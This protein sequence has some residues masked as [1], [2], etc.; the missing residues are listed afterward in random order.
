MQSSFPSI[1]SCWMLLVLEYHEGYPRWHI[2]N[3]TD[4]PWVVSLYRSESK[5]SSHVAFPRSHHPENS[6]TTSKLSCDSTKETQKLVGG[7]NP[8]EKYWSN[9][10]ICPGR[11][12]NKKHL[13]P[14]PRKLGTAK[15][16]ALKPSLA[17]ECRAATNKN[18]KRPSIPQP[19]QPF[20]L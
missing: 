16:L 17:S 18:S 3:D 7:F 14:P 9:W 6:S 4:N 8:I 10:I 15:T 20:P 19:P 12:K 2:A 5:S 13:K 1:Y 11:G